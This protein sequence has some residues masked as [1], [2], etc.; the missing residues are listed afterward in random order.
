MFKKLAMKKSEA[1]FKRGIMK[2][3]DF[4]YSF[5]NEP[6]ILLSEK[7]KDNESIGS[8]LSDEFDSD[9]GNLSNKR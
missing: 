7:L 1:P 6:V 9:D 5:F 2:F 8:L 4:N 3:D